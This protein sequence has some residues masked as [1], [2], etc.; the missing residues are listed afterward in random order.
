M[1]QGFS[2]ELLR[3]VFRQWPDEVRQKVGVRNGQTTGPFGSHSID[4]SAKT[5]AS[6]GSE[7]QYLEVYGKTRGTHRRGRSN[8]H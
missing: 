4:E 7:V 6:Q 5:G 3:W 1:N 8:A 2:T